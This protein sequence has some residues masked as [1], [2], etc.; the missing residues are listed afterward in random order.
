M[1]LR[2]ENLPP[3]T[4]NRTMPPTNT[5]SVLR[6]FTARFVTAAAAIAC[7]GLLGA[8]NAMAQG[9]PPLA[10]ELVPAQTALILIDFQYPFT[11]PDG[12][13]YRAIK[14]EL[15]EKHLLD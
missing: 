8:S 5:S 13:N 1:P 2:R 7:I 9:L 12:G 3:V 6:N 10:K 14:K 4:R 11:N 15:E